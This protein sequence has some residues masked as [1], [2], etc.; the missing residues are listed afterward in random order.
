MKNLT[1][2]LYGLILCGLLIFVIKLSMLDEPE[3]MVLIPAGD[4]IE[5]FYMD[6]YEV[7]NAEYKKFIDGNPQWRK[8]RALTA[9]VDDNY[10]SG[11]NSNMYPSGK[12]D[13]PV[14][15]VSWFAAKAY[16]EWVGKE[17]PTE[18]QWERAARGTLACKEYPWGDA[19]PHNRANYDRYTSGTNFRNPPTKRVGSYAPNTYGLYDM[20]GNVEE[21]CLERLDVNDIHGRYHR[22]RGGSWFSDAEDIQIAARSQH[23]VADGMGTLGFRCVLPQTET[24]T[25]KVATDMAAWLYENM[26]SQFD[27]AIFSVTEGLTPH[28]SLNA[29]FAAIVM[30]NTGYPRTFEKELIHVLCEATPGRIADIQEE[31]S[32]SYRDV[33]LRLWKHY[34]EVHFEH[35]SESEFGK[36]RIFKECL[37]KNIDNIFI[38]DGR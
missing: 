4:D 29:K 38:Q 27:S 17:L 33:I 32:N 37:K 5:A 13:H 24:K 3:D 28:A 12:A 9:I 18:A 19:D 36:L 20:A 35:S 16:A 2:I 8:S 26:R 11:W 25:T 23:P 15:N 34:L 31:E 22:M 14:V 7:T 10:L 21:W 1:S 30:H 6:V